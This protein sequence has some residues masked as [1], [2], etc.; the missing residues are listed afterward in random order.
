MWLVAL[1]DPPGPRLAGIVEL[2]MRGAVWEILVYLR[3][4]KD[5]RLIHVA[6]GR[7]EPGCL[8]GHMSVPDKAVAT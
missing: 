3:G 2:Y 6:I 4:L 7:D 5:E 1:V 8:A